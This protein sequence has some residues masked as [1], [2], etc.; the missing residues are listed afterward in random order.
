MKAKFE[1]LTIEFEPT[2]SQLLLSVK[3]EL[4]KVLEVKNTMYSSKDFKSQSARLFKKD[5][6]Q[7]EF[8]S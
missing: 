4:V 2:G 3:N 6:K 7:I 1:N 8:S 5:I